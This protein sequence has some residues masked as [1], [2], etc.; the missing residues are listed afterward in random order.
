MQTVKSRRPL[1]GGAIL[2]AISET[3]NPFFK[4]RP[5]KS[6]HGQVQFNHQGH[7]GPI[8]GQGGVQSGAFLEQRPMAERDVVVRALE[9]GAEGSVAPNSTCVL[10]K[11][12]RTATTAKH[13]SDKI[14]LNC[15]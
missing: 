14:S 9:E 1:G 11:N 4:A 10:L 2:K 3:V 8:A 5:L 6:L 13:T 15:F 7:A 12:Y